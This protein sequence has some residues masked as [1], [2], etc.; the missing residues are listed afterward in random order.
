MLKCGHCH[1]Q[2]G[3]RDDVCPVCGRLI[4]NDREKGHILAG[5][6]AVLLLTAMCGGIL[7]RALFLK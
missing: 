6:G 4:I 3:W 7:A 2:V 1:A 5:V